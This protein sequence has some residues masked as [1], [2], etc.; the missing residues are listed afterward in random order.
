M[1]ENDAGAEPLPLRPDLSPRAAWWTVAVLVA[2]H[3]ATFL[4]SAWSGSPYAW[5]VLSAFFSDI[6]ADLLGAGGSPWDGFDGIVAGP[7]VWAALEAPLIAVLG[8]VGLVHVLATAA[9]GVLG[10][11]LTALWL[12][13]HHSRLA[14]V[15]AVALMVFPPPNQW[16]H[17]H[18]GAY[19]VFAVPL[20]AGAF[21][22]LGAP[23]ASIGATA[24]GGLLL[25]LSISTQLGNGPV[26][27]GAALWW[28][29]AHQ[30][31][32]AAGLR[33]GFALL[34]GALIGVT[35]ML[36]KA[37]A[38]VP[39]GALVPPEGPGV[40]AAVKP[41]MLR[42]MGGADMGHRL[43]SML[44]R[45]GPYGMHW[46]IAGLPWLAAPWWWL[47]LGA[48]VLLFRTRTASRALVLGGIA[49]A[50]IGSL[51]TGWFVFFT[52]GE[53]P[54]SRDGRHITALVYLLSTAIAMVAATTWRG[55]GGVKRRVVAVA[56]VALLGGGAVGVA[57]TIDASGLGAPRWQ[58]PFRLGSRYVTGYFRAPYFLSAP[59]RAA[60][61]CAVLPDLQR[62]DCIR[63]VAFGFGSQAAYSMAATQ[64]AAAANLALQRCR[65]L[66]T[67]DGPTATELEISCGFGIGWGIADHVFRRPARGIS[68]CQV[69]ARLSGAIEQAC[70][71][72]VVWGTVQNFFDRPE[73]LAQWWSEVPPEHH[74][75]IAGG[76][77]QFL[78]MISTD[79]RWITRLCRRDLREDLVPA[80]LDAAARQARWMGPIHWPGPPRPA[81]DMVRRPKEGDPQ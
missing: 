8:H 32:T 5:T 4:L 72:G 47:G 77:G 73:A 45:E 74:S 2:A 69:E 30:P 12:M 35:P 48:A 41:L 40:A 17:A 13:R 26:A 18:A 70:A 67:K 6:A 22:R 28:W 76:T 20:F 66:A 36:W 33:R 57:R 46:E 59:E 79:G 21:L 58:T 53:V 23:G 25:G 50:L 27:V 55:D 71:E 49:G 52:P 3:V 80:C 29:L 64:E 24:F 15:L 1:P 42:P 56:L 34:G 14:A 81:F 61:S 16:V 78:G 60:E 38:H 51:A 7:M 19:H 39:Y 62:A 68:R 31:L 54:F 11:V 65:A 75:L 43:W 9:V 10:Q 44:V 63:G 37:V